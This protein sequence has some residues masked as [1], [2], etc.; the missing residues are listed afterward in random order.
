M[1]NITKEML[2]DEQRFILDDLI[3]KVNKLVLNGGYKTAKI[4]DR[5]FCI[6]GSAGTGKSTTISLLLKDFEEHNIDLLVTSPTHRAK[7]VLED[8]METAQVKYPSQTIHSYLKLSVKNNLETGKQDLT[9][10]TGGNPIEEYDGIIIEE[11][12]MI[13]KELLAYITAELE[14]DTFKFVIFLGDSYQLLAVG[15]EESPIFNLENIGQY[16]LHKVMR[17]KG[18]NPIIDI[19]TVLRD[20]IIS[21]KYLSNREIKELFL[22]NLG[23]H[24]EQVPDVKALLTRYFASE[25]EYTNNS[26]IAF[27]NKTVSSLNSKIRNK[28]VE[29]EECF[30]KDEELIFLNAMVVEDMVVIANN[31][32]ITIQSLKKIHDAE[33]GI[34]YWK[35]ID[36]QERLIRVV[37]LFSKDDFDYEL[38]ELSK[39]AKKAVGMERSNYWRRFFELKNTFQDV[40]Y[41]YA[42]TTFKAQGS[43]YSEVFYHLDEVLSMRNILGDENLFRAI[44]VGISRCK[45]K[46]IVLMK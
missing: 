36:D 21:G 37:D 28:I 45:H 24:I 46:L 31:E 19:C 18:G 12:S 35:I 30:I 22:E 3:P 43:S 38:S 23:E 5:M 17:Q 25:Y 1:G 41:V 44:Y 11:S 39:K 15:E 4:E 13:S 10:R 33:L 14:Q 9:Q 8:M 34:D 42:G 16:R 32:T 7:K 2:N 6:S 26:V 40:A 20:C 27:K 29:S